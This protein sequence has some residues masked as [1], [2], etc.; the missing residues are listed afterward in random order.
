MVKHFTLFKTIYMAIL[1]LV[2]PF[3]L[4]ACGQTPQDSKSP[5]SSGVPNG[6]IATAPLTVLSIVG[7]DV[8]IMK[9][10][11]TEWIRGEAGITLD[12]DCK[13]KTA[14]N[15][16]ATLTF[17]EGSVIELDGDTEIGLAELGMSGT[18]NT[19][20]LKQTLGKTMSRVKKLA[21]PASRY[22]IE[23]PAAVAAVRGTTMYVSVSNNGTT[24]VGNVEGSA[25]AIVN[26]VETKVSVGTHVTV[27]PGQNPGLPEPGA[28]PA[29]TTTAIPTSQSPTS[30]PEPTPISMA[31][32]SMSSAL[33]QSTVFNGDTIAITFTITNIGNIPVSEIVVTDD[34]AGPA[35]YA[36]GDENNN[37]VLDPG[38]IWIAEVKFTIPAD[39]TNYLNTSATLKGKDPD[40][41]PFTKSVLTQITITPLLVTIIPPKV[42]T[43]TNKFDLAGTVNDPSITSVT[44]HH[45]GVKSTVAVVK[46]NFSSTI[47]F[48][49]GN[50]I[51]TVRATKVGGTTAASQIEFTQAISP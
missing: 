1:I 9:P 51:I 2:L 33:N 22:E 20:K 36:G 6:K 48:V 45:N 43:V 34:K 5:E 13:I 35:V 31:N 16:Q 10:G 12:I 30:S 39:A 17:F 32:I 18:T 11:E 47:T 42:K 37:K 29:E 19:I 28:I 23:T 49:D 26:G 46:G 25:V 40:Q 41:K 8:L 50:N 44:V 38:E 4:L 24:V 7:G 3:G 27:Q 14:T 15:G 21:D